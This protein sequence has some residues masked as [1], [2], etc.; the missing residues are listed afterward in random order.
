MN[1]DQLARQAT[2][3]LLEVTGSDDVG[4]R[5]ALAREQRRRAVG[6]A[7]AWVGAAAL[8][9]V[10]VLVASPSGDRDAQPAEPDGPPRNGAL[11]TV[12]SSG[13][14]VVLDGQ[15]PTTAPR[16]VHP[17]SRIDFTANGAQM[18][19]QEPEGSLALIDL[20]TGETTSVGECSTPWCDADLS[21]AGDVIALVAHDED[22][23]IEVRP[24]DNGPVVHLS[25]PGTDIHSP[26]WSPDGSRLAF[27]ADEGL[28]VVDRD[29][30]DPRL[31]LPSA[32]DDLLVVRPSWSPDGSRLAFAQPQARPA[33]GS[34]PPG[35]VGHRF[36]LTVLD[37]E[38][39]ASEPMRDVGSCYCLG[40]A[41]PEA[42]WSPDGELIAVNAVRNGARDR[43]G[44]ARADGVYVVRPDGS[45]WRLISPFALDARMSWQPRV[46]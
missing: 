38:S 31:L 43:V 17:Y 25:T 8:V 3:E 28:F 20:G 2:R 22:P 1:L 42:V 10:A 21:P 30:S 16:T 23:R 32:T 34:D 40:I 27:A 46:E 4:R 37:I 29:G 7:G 45:G 33:E 18:M 19:V 36:V 24:I 39:G 14:V 6:R 44:A 12:D 9:T 15:L 11:V 35:M 5:A 13:S 26:V 41:A